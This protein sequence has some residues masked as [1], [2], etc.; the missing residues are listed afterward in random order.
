M[1]KDQLMQLLK[2]QSGPNIVSGQCKNTQEKQLQRQIK[3]YGPWLNSGSSAKLS[4][5][6]GQR[7]KSVALV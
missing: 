2:K 1:E 7:A 4:Y 3:R 5:R 6:Q